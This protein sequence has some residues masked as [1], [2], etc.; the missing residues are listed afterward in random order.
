M[1]L[2]SAQPPSNI[3]ATPAIAKRTCLPE[4]RSASLITHPTHNCTN[5]SI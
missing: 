5:N 1:Q 2:A 3:A 4:P